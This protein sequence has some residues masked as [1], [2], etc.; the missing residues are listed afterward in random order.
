MDKRTECR[1]LERR[2]AFVR[3]QRA[4]VGQRGRIYSGT[5]GGR[6]RVLRPFLP[7]TPRRPGKM[8]ENL[9]L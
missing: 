7:S 1:L 9:E 2:L 3:A 8:F 4:R 6:A 5:G